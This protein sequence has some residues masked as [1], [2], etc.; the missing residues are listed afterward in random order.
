MSD[1]TDLEHFKKKVNVCIWVF[2]I[3]L[4]LTFVT[5]LVSRF[6]I[7]PVHTHTG[8]ITLALVVAA[9]KAMLVAAYFMHLNAEKRSIYRIL[10]FT[11]IFAVGLMFL[12]IWAFYDPITL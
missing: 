6:H 12:T 1:I 5:V 10:A 4:V 11:G 2:V 3:L 7:G 9:V 8:N